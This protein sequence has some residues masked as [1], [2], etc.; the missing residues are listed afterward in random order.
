[1]QKI[2][3]CLWFDGQ[4]EEAARFYLSVFSGSRI[5]ATL[6]YTEASPGRTGD[7][8]AVTFEI[9]GQEFMALN[10]GPQY[11]FTPAI[12]L[13]VHCSSQAE[14]DR[15]WSALLDSGGK[16]MACGWLTDRY[17]VSWQIVPDVLLDMLRDPD[18]DKA[19]R[20]MA[21]MMKMIKLDI[22]E[23]EKAWRGD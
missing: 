20:V 3:P 4:A 9:E 14:V 16:T 5:A 17:G 22:G 23:L 19:N 1:M 8:L 2:A 15:Y 10:G 13:M 11:Q 12:S 6:H 21:A 7:V 18:H